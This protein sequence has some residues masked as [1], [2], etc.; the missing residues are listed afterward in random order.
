MDFKNE[1]FEYTTHTPVRIE[2][3]FLSHR[4][5]VHFYNSSGTRIFYGPS[6]STPS[7]I[8]DIHGFSTFES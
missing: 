8:Y 3:R 7:P 6:Y 2:Y 1:A 4:A 5:L